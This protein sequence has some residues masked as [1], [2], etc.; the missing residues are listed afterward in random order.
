M[1][2]NSFGLTT[3][4]AGSNPITSRSNGCVTARCF[5]RLKTVYA[6][7]KLYSIDKKIEF[8]PKF[9][10]S[11]LYEHH[12]TSLVF[13]ARHCTPVPWPNRQITLVVPFPPGGGTDAGARLIAQKLAAKRGQPVVVENKGGAAGQIGADLVAKAKSDGYTLLMGNIGTQSINPTLCSRLP[14]DADRAFAPISLVAELPLAMMV[15]PSVP[16]K[17]AIVHIPYRAV[18]PRANTP[19]Q[20]GKMIVDDRASYAR[21]IAERKI[22]VD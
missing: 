14:Y 12:T 2:V 16:A 13:S 22:T 20:F 18:G 11:P 9:G 19:A 1:P 7:T 5:C 15:N 6:D 3:A 8:K 21:I 4:F 10:D 17:T